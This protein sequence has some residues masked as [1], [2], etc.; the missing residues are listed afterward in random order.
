[1]AWGVGEGCGKLCP[2]GRSPF[3]FGI[4][5]PVGPAGDPF[6]FDPR[7]FGGMGFATF[8]FGEVGPGFAKLG[9]GLCPGP[10]V[11]EPGATSD[12]V[13]PLLAICGFTKGV[14]L[15]RPLGWGFCSAMV[16]L[17]FSAFWG[18]RP[19]HPFST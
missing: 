16:L 9:G 2:G 11:E 6:G 10:G 1:M 12:S 17:S 4:G 5:F 14:G 19:C 15:G 13:A 7:R 8:T 18:F 3:C